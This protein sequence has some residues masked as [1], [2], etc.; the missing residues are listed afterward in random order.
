MPSW[1]TSFLIHLLCFVAAVS[2]ASPNHTSQG[3]ASIVLNSSFA[4]QTARE[5]SSVRTVKIPQSLSLSNEFTDLPTAIKERNEELPPPIKSSSALS[6]QEDQ[7]RIE[8][9][10]QESE[11]A[12]KQPPGKK[13]AALT[14]R[15]QGKKS[16]SVAAFRHTP[17][18]LP[19]QNES[20]QHD[21]IVDRFIQ[22][23]VGQLRGAAGIKAR[24][25][26]QAL[27]TDALPALV[28]GLNRSADIH[29]TCPVGVIASKLL[30]TLR[31]ADSPAMTKYAID[32]IGQGVSESAPH[33]RRIVSLRDRFLT[34]MQSLPHKISD[35][36]VS[37]GLNGKEKRWRSR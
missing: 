19:S 36:F 30:Q 2:V 29:A 28:R 17:L 8:E 9:L 16:A 25:E 27:G 22:Y 20:N 11:Q 14:M 5:A 6:S 7:K 3:A 34:K 37:R 18:L 24:K 35:L 15:L 32:N 21:E 4:K 23:D 1:L 33:Y 10:I 26:F 12:P 13:Y 31:I